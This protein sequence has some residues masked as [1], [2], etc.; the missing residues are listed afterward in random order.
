MLANEKIGVVYTPLKWAKW[1]AEISGAFKAWT[2]GAS[3]VDPNV[4]E[5]I[6]IEAFLSL[7]RDKNISV[8][9][10]MIDALHGFDLRSDGIDALIK[11]VSGIYSLNLNPKNFKVMDIIITPIDQKFDYVIGNP[12]WVNF[13]NLPEDY[14]ERLK[15]EY[16]NFGLIANSGSVLLGNSRVDISA[17]VINVCVHKLMGSKSV[18]AMFVPSSLFFGG[19]AHS[20][21]RNF[22][23]KD[24]QFFLSRIHDFGSDPIFDGSSIHGTP[25]CFAEFKLI[26]PTSSF[27]Y[28]KKTAK[29]FWEKSEISIS[30]SNSNGFIR[31][32][33]IDNT[34]LVKIPKGSKP[35]QGVNTGGRNSIFMGMIIEG[36]LN[37]NTVIFENL[38]GERFEIES[39]LIYPL[40]LRENLKNSHFQPLRYLIMA[41]NASTGRILDEGELSTHK[42]AFRYFQSKQGE[43]T[44]RKG[45]LINVNIQKG[46][47]WGLMGVGKY[48]FAPFKIV[49]LTAGEKTFKPELIASLNGK[50]WQ[51]NQSL[52]AFLPF[53]SKIQAEEIF[54]KLSNL[55]KSLDP[56]LLGTPGTLGWGQPGRMLNI[57]AIE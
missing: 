28:Y 35:R 9:T 13:N 24:K 44:S 5:G 39:A 55:A 50:S 34:A 32:V 20:Y 8:T 21:F 7:A 12:P 43:L 46:L 10:E 45:L 49:W 42:N 47:Y 19:S 52:Q 14:K 11:R 31:T 27:A 54:L 33:N 56:E 22:V 4:G 41:H 3:V 2:K 17:L 37:D 38:D 51:A 16:V 25:Y 29:D 15:V 48:S 57:L 36:S 6:F 23:S 26:P 1:A 53:D 30:K 40:L 18:L